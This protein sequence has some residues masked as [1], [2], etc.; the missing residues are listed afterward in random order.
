MT[1]QPVAY[2]V[3]EGVATITLNRPEAMNS[4]NI[5]TKDALVE[6]TARAADDDVLRLTIGS[7]TRRLCR[8]APLPYRADP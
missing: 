7:D 4:L 8:T 2:D 6:A 5:A 1:D 3:V